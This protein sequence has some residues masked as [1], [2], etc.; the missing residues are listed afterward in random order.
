[1]L[2]FNLDTEYYNNSKR[3]LTGFI[4]WS[5]AIRLETLIRKR[6]R[7]LDKGYLDSQ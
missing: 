2:L 5:K 7:K 4:I 6:K 3:E 1:M